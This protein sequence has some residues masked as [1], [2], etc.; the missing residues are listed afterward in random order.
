MN[1]LVVFLIFSIGWVAG[2]L[3]VMWD[4]SPKKLDDET[5]RKMDR[6]DG[7]R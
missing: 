2:V 4:S 1:G 7:T 5:L 3:T 6:W